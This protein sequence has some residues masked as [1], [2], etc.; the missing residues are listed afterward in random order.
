MRVDILLASLLH[1]ARLVVLQDAPSQVLQV[2]HA[3]KFLQF[4]LKVV[5]QR[6]FFILGLFIE[7]KHLGIV[8]EHIPLVLEASRSLRNA[9]DDS[10]DVSW[11]S[12]DRCLVP[13]ESVHRQFLLTLL[14]REVR[15]VF[16]RVRSVDPEVVVLLQ[17]VVLEEAENLDGVAWVIG[18]DVD[19][20]LV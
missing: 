12:V 18:T 2:V 9:V 10:L 4:L 6:L 17:Q 7:I 1:L 8:L 15:Q 14:Q 20:S 13:P 19:Q 5:L 3:A 16:L 11:Q